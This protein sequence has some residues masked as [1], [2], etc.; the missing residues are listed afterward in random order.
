V[1]W[2]RFRPM[3]ATVAACALL[4]A[5]TV[6]WPHPLAPTPPVPTVAV[7]NPTTG[8]SLFDQVDALIDDALPPTLQALAAASDLDDADADLNLLVPPDGETQNDESWI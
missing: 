6:W 2:W 7:R 8:A 4:F 3:W 1:S 5:F